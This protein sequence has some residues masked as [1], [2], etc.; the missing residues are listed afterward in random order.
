MTRKTTKAYTA[1]FKFI[2]QRIFKMKPFELMT[3]YED[4]MRLA[5]KKQWPKALIHGCWFHYKRAINRNCTKLGMN[6]LLKKNANARK[7]KRMI[8]NIP[9]LPAEQIHDG[10]ENIKKFAAQ[11]RL[12]KRF[13]K[14]FAYFQRYWL[15]QVT[16][17][18][19][20]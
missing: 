14:L 20:F 8:A 1:V 13:A 17:Y 9:L 2:E 16:F 3:D 11:K 19:I 5:I 4:G 15:K 6:S 10:Y 18:I 7:I 12:Y